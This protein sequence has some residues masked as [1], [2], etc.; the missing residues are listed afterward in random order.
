MRVLA[1][2]TQVPF[3]RGGAEFLAEGLLRSLIAAGHEAELVAIPFK[4]Y[5]PD[6]ILDHMLACRLLDL[7][8]SCGDSIDRVI[9]LKF[10][11]Y[12]IPHPRKVMWLVHQ[13]R[14]AYDL[15]Q[16]PLDDLSRFPNGTQVRQSII[17]ADHQAFAESQ[18][19]FT[20]AEN[21][22]RRLKQF[23]GVDSTPLYSPPAGAEQFHSAEATDYLFFPSRL[24]VMK[25]QQLV[26]EA[27]ALTQYSVKV[28][29]AGRSDDLTMRQ[30]LEE[31]ID[32]LNL[33]DRVTFLDAISEADKIYHYAHCLGV[34]YPP[35]DEDYGYVTLEAMLAA[36][37]VITCTDAGGP[38]E[39]VLDQ[40]T[41][42]VAQPQPES[43]AAAM[44]QVW[45]DRQQA[46]QWGKA[47]RDR[48]DSMNIS[49]NNV[50][51][52]LLAV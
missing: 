35:L 28:K 34:I 16:S 46:A 23:N 18:G 48:Y 51:D 38:L 3:V 11:T 12:L 39:F 2:T 20:I 22:S 47:G 1:L 15:W 36:K 4:W 40:I 52:Q 37:P 19:N 41:G 27:L 13:H 24:N 10:P 45:D 21:V 33:G 8:E 29:F 14:S 32:K 44:D 7:S 9:G 49:W 26:I 50:V 6:R 5:P 30:T 42:L 31:R 17:Q 43:L 25:R